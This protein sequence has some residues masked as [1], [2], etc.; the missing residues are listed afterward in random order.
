MTQFPKNLPEPASVDC[1]EDDAA[2]TT[3]LRQHRPPI[4]A[5]SP[6]GEHRLMAV[7]AE[8]PKGA[9]EQ[10][11]SKAAIA[12]LRSAS[13]FRPRWMTST[14]LAASLI[15]GM[16]GIMLRDRLIPAQTEATQTNLE[17]FIDSTWHPPTQD[18]P[19]AV[20][21]FVTETLADPAPQ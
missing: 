19:D 16:T 14:A 9:N 8:L 6:D 11:P 2:L 12:P 15:A 21:L 4:P 17:A 7:L 13:R 1:S 5:A 10:V 20:A 18:N 3:F